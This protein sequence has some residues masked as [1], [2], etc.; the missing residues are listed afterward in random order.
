MNSISHA[1]AG[2]IIGILL[3]FEREIIFLDILLFILLS[4]FMD[5]DHVINL[6]LHKPKYHLRSFIQEPFAILL[7]G[8]P[9]GFTLFWIFGDI[10]YFWLVILIYSIH[11]SLDYLCIF[12][13]YPLDPFSR[14]VVKREGSGIILP[15]GPEWTERKTEFP[16]TFEEKWIFLLLIIFLIILIIIY[17]I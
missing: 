4:T 13:T 15:F 2:S 10:I 14:K 16:N 1:L 5:L 3:F 6:L 7:I 11:I 17:L 8:I 12:E 9:L